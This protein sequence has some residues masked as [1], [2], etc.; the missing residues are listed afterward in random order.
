MCPAHSRP[1]G[2]LRSAL[3]AACCLVARAAMAE[4]PEPPVVIQQFQAAGGGFQVQVQVQGRGRVQV[5]VQG[6]VAAAAPQ[7]AE[8]ADPADALE[9][10]ANPAA[11]MA[12][13]QQAQIKEQAREIEVYIRPVLNGELELIRGA[14]GDLPQAAR[15]AILAAG[16]EAVTKAALAYARQQR[17][18]IEG[19][20]AADPRTMIRA[21]VA[22]AVAEQAGAGAS[23]AYRAEVAR[24]DARRAKAARVRI[25]AKLESQLELSAEQRD[26]I[27][28]DLEAK[29]QPAWIA[30][31]EDQGM[32]INGRPLAPDFCDACVRRHLD[33][34]QRGQWDTWRKAAGTAVFGMERMNGLS[35]DGQGLQQVDGWWSK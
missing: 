22:D 14:C 25:V 5:Q 29:W 31:L 4:E 8:A 9:Q 30:A 35:F 13:Q 33:D 11:A 3:L 34:T 12:M 27:E 21:Q 17:F 24:R 19:R 28:R 15:R 32:V 7:P 6:G 26:A 10:A 16:R 2:P 18:G 20:R 23:A 1:S